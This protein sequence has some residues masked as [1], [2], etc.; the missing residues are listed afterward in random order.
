MDQNL[1]LYLKTEQIL[2][3][4]EN[5]ERY[6][7]NHD[8]NNFP[9]FEQNINEKKIDNF[10]N[11]INNNLSLDRESILKK[12]NERILN[13]NK[14]IK[15]EKNKLENILSPLRIDMQKERI[16]NIPEYQMNNTLSQLNKIKA[17]YNMTSI[18]L[19]K[20]FKEIKVKKNKLVL[21]YNSLFNF[22]QKLLN[23]EKE[24]KEKEYQ[25]NKYE[26][27]LKANENILKTNLEEFNNYVN[28]QTKNLINKFTNI[29]NYHERK[30]DELL[31]REEKINE[32]EA[33]IRNM[34]YKNDNRPKQK[35]INDISMNLEMEDN[36]EERL[37]MEMEK[38]KKKEKENQ[39]K[40]DYEK[41]EK[42]K[43]QIEKEKELIQKE[44]EQLNI[45]KNKKLKKKNNKRSK[46]LKMRKMYIN[47]N[48][49][50]LGKN[51]EDIDE[52]NFNFKFHT[53]IRDN[54]SNMFDN[55][56][57]NYFTQAKSLT[58]ISYNSSK[59]KISNPYNNLN[60]NKDDSF[61]TNKNN[62]SININKKNYSSIQ[63]HHD[64]S[65]PSQNI[66]KS[67]DIYIHD[68]IYLLKNKLNKEKDNSIID[69]LKKFQPLTKRYNTSRFSYEIM[70]DKN[71]E[72]LDDNCLTFRKL[73][74]NT[75]KNKNYENNESN[76]KYI[77]LKSN[78]NNE[79]YNDINKKIFEAEKALQIVKSQEN[80][81]KMI[82]DKLDK[83]MKYSS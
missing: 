65:F 21:V 46:R 16:S 26:N 54:I 70:R 38:I 14:S 39:I 1:N 23:K 15:D 9:F 30:E 31:L 17:I 3:A 77:E 83:K 40:K 50:Q 80:R 45:E 53:P 64:K 78:E 32:Y 41:I 74:L 22:K 71:K 27:E 42:E 10:D 4:T 44:K 19:E 43:E 13:L 62:N 8:Y 55:F 18:Q 12:N 51:A 6:T 20:E 69:S 72:N 24:I 73:N 7:T 58:P 11:Y 28:L 36:L 75:V 61:I 57:N 82:K 33:I 5:N 68:N 29:K 37:D 76:S 25:I 48:S 47:L 67:K 49:H 2:K 79:E 35:L 59:Y 63:Y 56:Y 34:I 66:S 60:Y 52:D 81:I